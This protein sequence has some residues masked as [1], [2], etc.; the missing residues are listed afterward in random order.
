MR[1][2]CLVQEMAKII[3]VKT[4]RTYIFLKI[5]CQAVKQREKTFANLPSIVIL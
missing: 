3:I 5:F 2:Y 1:R 4:R